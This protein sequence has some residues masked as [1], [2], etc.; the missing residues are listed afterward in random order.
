MARNIKAG[1]MVAFRP[2]GAFEAVS[3]NSR[4]NRADIYVRFVG[5]PDETLRD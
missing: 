3:R 1:S 2:K 4:G 5:V